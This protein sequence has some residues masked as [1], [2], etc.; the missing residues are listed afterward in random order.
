M[1]LKWKDSALVS[2]DIEYDKMFI[3]GESDYLQSRLEIDGFLFLNEALNSF[4]FKQIKRGQLDGWLWDKDDP[5]GQIPFKIKLKTENG[6]LYLHLNEEKNI[7]DHAFL[8]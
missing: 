5:A 8:D 2:E 6:E 4:G 1:K 7:I 3:K